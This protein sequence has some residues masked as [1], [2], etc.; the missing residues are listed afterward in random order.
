MIVPYAAVFTTVFGLLIYQQ[1]QVYILLTTLAISLVY[2]IQRY[3][4]T[5]AKQGCKLLRGD[6]LF[7]I[8]FVAYLFYFKVTH[9]LYYI[10]LLLSNVG[11]LQWLANQKGEEM[12]VTIQQL[13]I[14]QNQCEGYILCTLLVE[15]ILVNRASFLRFL[16]Y[17]LI[18]KLKY[19]FYQP[20]HKAYN[21]IHFFFDRLSRRFKCRAIYHVVYK[22]ISFFSNDIYSTPAVSDILY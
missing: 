7:Q 12:N 9:F 13:I 4:Q 20:T 1:S 2:Y 15:S 6:L 19:R 18:V 10:P 3:F 5:P 11:K 14:F 8:A 17:G 16:V 21:Q 22:I